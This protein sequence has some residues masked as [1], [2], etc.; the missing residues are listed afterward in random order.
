MPKKNSRPVKDDLNEIFVEEYDGRVADLVAE[1]QA[2]VIL[3]LQDGTLAALTSLRLGPRCFY[4]HEHGYFY[5]MKEL[6]AWWD[7][8]VVQNAVA[9]LRGD[10]HRGFGPNEA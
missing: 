8:Q 5:T 2:E 6:Q 4:V 7:Q 9:F 3:S 10:Q 1:E